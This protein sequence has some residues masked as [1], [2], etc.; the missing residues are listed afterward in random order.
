M[1]TMDFSFPKPSPLFFREDVRSMDQEAILRLE[2]SGIELMERAGACTFELIRTL[3]PEARTLSAVAGRGNNGGDAYIVARLALE[4][5]WDVSVYPAPYPAQNSGDAGIAYQRYQAAGGRV[6]NFIPEDFEGAEI[7]L[8]GLYGTG[9]TRTVEGPDAAI[10]GAANRYRARGLT[11]QSNQRTVIALD[12]PSGLDANTGGIHGCAIG[13]DHTITFIAPKFGLFTAMGPSLSGKIHLAELATDPDILRAIPPRGLLME[14]PSTSPKPRAREA[15]KGHFG[16]VLIIGGHPGFA[17]AARLAGEAAA[18]IG[19]GRVTIGTHPELATTLGATRPELMVHGI[20][21]G[22]ALNALINQ[23]SVI[24]IGPGLGNGPWAKTLLDATLEASCPLVV[25]ADGLRM[26]ASSP[27]KRDNWILTPHP[28]EA[29]ALLGTSS[30]SIQDDR[31]TALH[32]ISKQYGGVCILKGSGTLIGNHSEPVRIASRGNPGMASGGM[33]DVL[34]G[35][36]AGLIAQGMPPGDAAGAGVMLHGAAADLSA[37]TEGE[38][39]LLASD[40]LPIVRQLLNQPSLLKCRK[41]LKP[42]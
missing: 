30:Q 5:G 19:A 35:I 29:A 39:G 8:D 24:A 1:I 36:L 11:H 4:A 42:L 23:A 18:R 26:L 7:L 3:R 28:G 31:Y 10:I 9:L 37:A 27:Q 20:Q 22:E 2:G 21:T 17:G 25:D 34:T 13:A 6:L 40:L 15:H 12:L 38:R 16:H 33:G 32:A 41:P 14:W